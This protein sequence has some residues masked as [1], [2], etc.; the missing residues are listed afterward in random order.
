MRTVASFTAFLLICLAPRLNA[1]DLQV[2]KDPEAAQYV[3]KNVE[4]RGLVVAVYTSKKGN[5]FLNFGAKYPNQTFTGYIPAGSELAG[6]R[7][8]VTLQG[9]RWLKINRLCRG[10]LDNWRRKRTTQDCGQR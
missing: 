2:I 3:G 8:T 6:D 5:T 9:R 4:V 10:L 1:Q 7:W